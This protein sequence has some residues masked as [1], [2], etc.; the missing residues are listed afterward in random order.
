MTTIVYKEGVVAYDSQLTDGD[1]QTV[2][3]DDFD[4][5]IISKSKRFFFSGAACDYEEFINCYI[6]NK[7][8]MSNVSAIVVDDNR[9]YS[10]SVDSE[11]K[12]WRLDITHM[13]YAIGS[14]ADHALTAMDCGLG[15]KD[16]V[17][18]AMKRDTGTGG[19]I[20]SFKIKLTNK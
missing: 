6:D 13:I 5:C 16:A 17:K 10:S 11:G 4:K 14:G 1:G 3:D 12:I 20:R 19:R 15:A 9:V 7:C 8:A 2:T 18:M